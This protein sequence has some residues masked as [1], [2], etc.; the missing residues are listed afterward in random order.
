V[1]LLDRMLCEHMIAGP[2]KGGLD[3]D[4]FWARNPSPFPMYRFRLTMVSIVGTLKK[5]IARSCCVPT[6]DYGH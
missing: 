2:L 1:I 5:I 6:M 4:R 3:L